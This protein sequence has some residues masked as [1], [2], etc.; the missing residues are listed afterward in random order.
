MKQRLTRF[1]AFSHTEDHLRVK[2]SLG[3]LITLLGA[4]LALILFV[5]EA[6]RC[7]RVRYVQ[8]MAVDTALRPTMYMEYNITFPALPCQ[9]IRMDTGDVGGKFETES[10]HQQ[11]HDGEV[12]KYKLDALGRRKER[13]E[14]IPP[15]GRDNPFVLTLDAQDMNEVREAVTRHEG[16]NVFGWLQVQRVAGNVHFAVRS[17][18]ILAVSES[19]QALQALFD[20]HVQIHGDTSDDDFHAIQL[21]SSHV[22]HTLRFGVA[23]FNG[24]QNPLEGVRRIDRKATGVD[25]YFIKVV[26]T[27]YV[28]LWGWVIETYQYSV[29]EYYSPLPEGS[30]SMPGVYLLYDTSPIQVNV[31]ATRLGVLHL[32]VRTCAVVGGVWAITG[33]MNRGVHKGLAAFK[34]ITATG[35]A[36]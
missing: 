17:E 22:I 33:A 15:R 14:Y 2:T 18:A 13:V 9:A 32:L 8:E 3:G 20:R 29:T 35:A 16:C 6:S 23:H 36:P 34:R 7:L 31:R 27:E 10:M 24:Q 19:E 26:P 4:A 12:H 1:S 5:S 11:I 30:K 25:K 28:S 21:N